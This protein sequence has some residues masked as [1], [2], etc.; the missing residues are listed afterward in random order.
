MTGAI[1][2]RVEVGLIVLIAIVGLVEVVGTESEA[3]AKERERDDSPIVGSVVEGSDERVD[4][5][6]AI[7]T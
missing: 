4:G 6:E 2:D 5:S 7:V 1:P 3:D